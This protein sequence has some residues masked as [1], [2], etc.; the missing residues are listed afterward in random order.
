MKGDVYT[1]DVWSVVCRV[2]CIRLMCG[3]LCAG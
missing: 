1:A 3:V 2:T